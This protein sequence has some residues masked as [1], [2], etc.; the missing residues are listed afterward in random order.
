MEHVIRSKAN[1][2]F[3]ELLTLLRPGGA[4]R[5]HTLLLGEKLIEAWRSAPHAGR[6]VP[7]LLLVKEESNVPDWALELMVPV[8]WLGEKLMGEL[9]DAASPPPCALLLRL[10]PEPGGPLKNRVIVPWGIQDPGNLGAIFRSAAAFG[11]Q[12]AL[13]GPGCAD[14]FSPKALRGSMGAAFLL[15]IRR[16]QTLDAGAD[17]NEGGPPGRFAP[18]T[19]HLSAARASS[20][21]QARGAGNPPLVL[22]HVV[23]GQSPDITSGNWFALDGGADSIPLADAELVEPLRILVG[24]EGH[25]WKHESLPAAVQRVAIPTI[26]VESLN[27]A[28]AAGIACHEVQ[29]RMS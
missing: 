5:T 26:G 13:L 9:G 16:I 18:S 25:G 21:S 3:K 22:P 6:L 17:I 27:A 14:P 20:R 29:R 11:F 23:P 28:V 10:G 7:E 2:R 12:E 24:N 19:S 8:Q 1:P 15:A 4:A